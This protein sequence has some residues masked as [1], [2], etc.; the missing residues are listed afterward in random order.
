[1]SQ[2]A[3]NQVIWLR[4]GLLA[5]LIVA[6]LAA[7]SLYS[8]SLSSSYPGYGGNADCASCHNEPATAYDTT[9]ES[10]T[11]NLD[12]NSSDAIWSNTKN[13]RMEIPV[14]DMYGASE[15][16]I[17]VTF[18]QNTTHLFVLADWEDPT[19]NGTDTGMYDDAD[20]IAFCWNISAADFSA[21]YF[22]G[23]KTPDA[24]EK[25]DTW[26]WKPAASETGTQIAGGGKTVSGTVTDLSYNTSGWSTDPSQSVLVAA[27]HGNLSEH[28][29]ENYRVEFVRPL[30]TDD[31]DDVQFDKS[32]YYEF[33]IGIYN[34]S[35]GASH[36][37]SFEHKVW[38]KAQGDLG[39]ESSDDNSDDSDTPGFEFLAV[40]SA[41]MVLTLIASAKD[42]RKR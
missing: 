1:M 14:G 33:A 4:K 30:V 9:L 18:A 7:V 6:L 42:R 2:K 3:R 26:S 5:V 38:V 31:P 10:E 16:F 20:G 24:G 34:G 41:F 40:G 36:M 23:M 32:G 15:E 11:I 29:E 12:G 28:H 39:H 22:S 8:L 27:T 19:I 37:V 21:A 13:R 17:Q 25:V 35:S